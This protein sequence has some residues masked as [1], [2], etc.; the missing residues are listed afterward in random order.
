MNTDDY[1]HLKK[2][3]TITFDLTENLSPSMKRSPRAMDCWWAEHQY[4]VHYTLHEEDGDRLYFHV[5]SPDGSGARK[6]GWWINKKNGSL[7]VLATHSM[8]DRVVEYKPNEFLLKR[9]YDHELDGFKDREITS[10]WYEKDWFRLKKESSDRVVLVKIG[11]FYEVFHQDAIIFRDK[12]EFPL[13]SST[14]A[15]TGFPQKS[16]DKFTVG[17]DV[18]NIPYT[19]LNKD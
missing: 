7:Y 1:N 13:M 19:I 14:Y 17:M 3:G 9:V 2:N 4:G 15:H 11:S 5:T 10:K 6:T 8:G 16:L 12:F 18:K